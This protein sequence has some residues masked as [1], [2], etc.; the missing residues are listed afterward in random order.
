M[1]RIIH[2]EV[3]GN[4]ARASS[5]ELG[6]QGEVAAAVVALS[7]DSGWD[8][9]AK[10]LLWRSASGAESAYT[11]LTDPDP[12]G[13]YFASV[14]AL[15]LSEAG[16]AAL[17]VEGVVTSE[18]TV[19][20]RARS[21]QLL[22]RVEPNDLDADSEAQA[23]DATVAEQLASAL[24]GK[25]AASHTHTKSDVSDFS[26]THAQSEVTGLTSALAG[27][28]ASSHTHTKSAITNFAH[29]HAQSEVTGL[30]SALAGKAAASHTHTKSAVTDFAHTHTKSDV[31]DFSHTHTKSDITDFAH[32]HE[33]DASGVTYTP[34]GG[35]ATDVGSALDALSLLIAADR[36]SELSGS[37]ASAGWSGASA[38][39]TQSFGCQAVTANSHVI[40][41]LPDNA[42]D[43]QYEAACA[44]CLRFVCGSGSVTA[45]AYGV[46]PTVALPIRIGVIK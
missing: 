2:I 5:R 38:P 34:D 11:L 43:A 27:K 42:T 3:A 23:I 25:A 44:A 8:G 6:T 19:E 24:E 35:G 15:P 33:V 36:V 32:T 1:Q 26:H 30:T 14:P 41:G 22:F 16:M 28:A 18:E 40:V 46:K 12:H 39:Y 4:R 13:V 9:Y 31:T 29:T 7:F 21:V 20:R 37:L 45:K 10:R 17:C